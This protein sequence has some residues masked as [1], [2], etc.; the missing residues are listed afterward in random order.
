MTNDTDNDVVHLKAGEHLPV[1]P[2]STPT[3]EVLKQLLE[4]MLENERR[5]LRNEYVR[6][7]MV[8]LAILA[9]AIGSGLW[10]TGRL[11]G[12]LREERRTSERSLRVLMQRIAPELADEERD[13]QADVGNQ[14]PA[15]GNRQSE[16]GNIS[17]TNTVAAQADIKRRLGELDSKNR[18]LSD[19]LKNQNAQTKTLLQSRDNELQALHE[20]MKE[21]QRKVMDAAPAETQPVRESRAPQEFTEKPVESL[22][23]TTSNAMPL[24]LPIP[25]P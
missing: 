22:T 19:M 1:A 15:I 7:T 18:T 12:Q 16:I 25:A 9:L 17:D 21:V 10:F 3:T 6:I 20:R 13:Q 11:L 8:I 23:I 2:I 4:Q 14:R 24:R 5:R